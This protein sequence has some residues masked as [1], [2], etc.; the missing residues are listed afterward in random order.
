MTTSSPAPGLIGLT[1]VHG[2]VG[3]LIEFGQ[4]LN[5]DGFKAWE[6]A[7]IS[8]G[9]GLIV[10]A[11]PDG[12]RVAHVTE[13]SVIHWCTN[14]FAPITPQRAVLIEDAAKK[15]V[16]VPYSAADYFALAA[17]RLHIP[18]PGLQHFIADS[19]HMI[20]SQLVDQC[21]RDAGITLFSGRWPG[22]VTPA[23]L[24]NLDVRFGKPPEAMYVD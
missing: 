21:Y 19:G 6:H 2:E 4:W 18:A 13:Y 17:H 24:Y 20:C 12:A 22:Y 9:N 11:E 3:K 7:F 1:P 10:E 23:D 8:I 15:Y 5:G 14:I 16:G